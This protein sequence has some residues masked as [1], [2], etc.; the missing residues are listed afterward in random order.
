M[1]GFTNQPAILFL[2][3]NVRPPTRTKLFFISKNLQRTKHCLISTDQVKINIIKH[4]FSE[5]YEEI[6]TKKS[7]KITIVAEL[8]AKTSKAAAEAVEKIQKMW[9]GTEK[10]LLYFLFTT[11]SNIFA[12]TFHHQ[13]KII[14]FNEHLCGNRNVG[15]FWNKLGRIKKK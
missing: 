5:S 4:A 3:L 6:L 11:Y 14:E 8:K 15:K 12:Q 9:K 2:A 1:F 7:P 13:V 10:E